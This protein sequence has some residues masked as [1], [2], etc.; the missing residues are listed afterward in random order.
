MSS[1]GNFKTNQY[2]SSENNDNLSILTTSLHQAM[3]PVRLEIQMS[4]KEREIMAI[5]FQS[6]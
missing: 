2:N 6:Q 3:E 1:D 4:T 5:L